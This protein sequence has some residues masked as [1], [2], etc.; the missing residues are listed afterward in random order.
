MA[1]VLFTLPS[2]SLSNVD[3]GGSYSDIPLISSVTCDY[4]N[5]LLSISYSTYGYVSGY[6]IVKDGILTDTVKVEYSSSF[7]RLTRTTGG[8]TKVMDFYYDSNNNEALTMQIGSNT[9]MR[10]NYNSS[11]YLSE[12][13]LNSTGNPLVEYEYNSGAISNVTQYNSSH[14]QISS[15][16]LYD[17]DVTL[18]YKTAGLACLNIL[19]N[20]YNNY[21]PV[22]TFL[23]IGGYI[24]GSFSGIEG[25]YSNFTYNID[26]YLTG[27][28]MTVDDDPYSVTFTYKKIGS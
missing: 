19:Y 1:G 16:D 3:N 14:E 24:P 9:I 17:Y 15:D 13:I 4:D 27:L 7:I 2:C 18:S 23:G 6:S 11:S 12:E 28:T 10:F 21:Q 22:L 5:S 20:T 26:G 25:R 8:A